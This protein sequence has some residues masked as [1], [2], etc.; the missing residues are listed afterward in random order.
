MVKAPRQSPSADLPADAA[1]VDAA[2]A[3][4]DAK[5]WRRMALADVAAHLRV[6]VA[7]LA[8]VAPTRPALISLIV[9]DIDRRMLAAV[10]EADEIEPHRDRLFDLVM[11]RLEILAP[12]RHAVASLV[13]DTV[14]DPAALCALLAEGRRSAM[15]TL[16]AAGI[17]TRGCWGELRIQAFGAL[18]ARV[19][20]VWRDDDTA[21]LSHTMKAL[22]KALDQ[23]IRAEH[24]AC[25]LVPRSV[26]RNTRQ[27][28]SDDLA[29]NDSASGGP[30]PGADSA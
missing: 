16:E 6:P 5:G 13:R 18:Q 14:T 23:A 24:F 26:R 9:R 1:V 15:L 21:D 4:L 12:H 8:A 2:L 28:D 19:L 30:V 22:D 29:P 25:T 17:S 20:R 7:R 10:T 3:V 27:G 11:R